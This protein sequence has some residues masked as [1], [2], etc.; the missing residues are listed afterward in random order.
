M[1]R[2][3]PLA[4]LLLLTTSITAQT[5]TADEKIKV[6]QTIVK[7]FDGISDLDEAAIRSHITKDFLLLED[8]AV[9]NIDTLTNQ[10][11]QLRGLTVSRIN[12]LNFIKTEILE[13]SAWVA[14]HNAA[15]ITV[16]GTEMRVEWLE[17][18]F[19]VRHGADWKI[20]ML[21]STSLKP[22]SQQ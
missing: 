11:Q 20:E 12:H 9:W 4:M 16:N 18:A 5:K 2:I 10:F 1:K 6:H 21:H 3:L 17:S 8:G 15:D 22:A 19:L 14:Y 13:R 7:L